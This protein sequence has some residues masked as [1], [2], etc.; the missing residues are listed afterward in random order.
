VLRIRSAV[1]ADGESLKRLARATI[2]ASFPRFRELRLESF[3]LNA[4]A[5]AFY[6]K[7]GWSEGSC[8]LDP[9][10]GVFKVSFRKRRPRASV[11]S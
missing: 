10:S 4:Q 2:R 7:H 1:D 3:E 11:S 6:R 9:D 8:T 5:N